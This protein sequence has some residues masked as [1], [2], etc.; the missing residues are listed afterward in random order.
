M[1]FY[2]NFAPKII[3]IYMFKQK[4]LETLKMARATT[5]ADLITAANGQFEKLWKLI[6]SMMEEE[7]NATFAFGDDFLQKQNI[8][9][10]KYGL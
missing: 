4:H 1:I 5:K 3:S 9:M 6:D 2:G 8:K 7:K 10:Q